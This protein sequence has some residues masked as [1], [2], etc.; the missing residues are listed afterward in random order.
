LSLERDEQDRDEFPARDPRA[1]HVA[2]DEHLGGSLA[3]MLLEF[4]D[5]VPTRDE[6]ANRFFAKSEESTRLEATGI[7][8]ERAHLK[9]RFESPAFRSRQRYLMR[10]VAGAVALSSAICVAAFV[11]ATLAPQS[12]ENAAPVRIAAAIQTAPAP[13]EPLRPI[14][15]PAATE[16]PAPI[17]APVVA[18]P[19]VAR[20]AMAAGPVAEATVP[21]AEAPRAVPAPTALE[22]KAVALRALERGEWKAAATAAELSV[23]LDPKDAEAWLALG[24]A[25]QQRGA[26]GR[27]HRAYTSCSR[28]A[29]PGTSRAEC[30]A[31]A[32]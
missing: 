19:V 32:K 9:A 23:E 26:D 6:A 20:S 15:M 11:R 22:A 8:D 1:T 17:T 29:R 7:V 5:E 2:P 10:Y 28:L 12:F 24:G 14:E 13:V 3:P 30:V 27:A 4:E 25:Y 18:A 31:L 16:P 21:A